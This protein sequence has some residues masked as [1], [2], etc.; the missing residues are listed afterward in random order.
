MNPPTSHASFTLGLGDDVVP[1]PRSSHSAFLVS[2]MTSLA[3]DFGQSSMKTPRRR[4]S[5]SSVDSNTSGTNMD[6][7]FG[8]RRMSSSSLDRGYHTLSSA[9]PTPDFAPALDWYASPALAGVSPSN[10]QLGVGFLPNEID[11]PRRRDIKRS[12]S[13]TKE[14]EPS[15]LF[16]V[17]EKKSGGK[18]VGKP[19]ARPALKRKPFSPIHFGSE[20]EKLQSPTPV[21]P[22]E[23]IY[24]GSRKEDGFDDAFM[25][26]DYDDGSQTLSSSLPVSIA[27]LM[28]GQIT[29]ISCSTATQGLS[30][31]I[32]RDSPRLSVVGSKRLNSP[33][34]SSLK[35]CKKMRAHSISE[36]SPSRPSVND[37]EMQ[38]S[39]PIKRSKSIAGIPSPFIDRAYGIGCSGPD[40]I[41]DFSKPFALPV[42]KTSKGLKAI[43]SETLSHL[44]HGKFDS[45]IGSYFVID[46]RF[47]FEFSGGH[48]KGA[49]NLFTKDQIDAFFLQTPLARNK[50][51]DKRLILIFHC[52]FSS[53]RGPNLCSFLRAQ[54]RSIHSDLDKYPGLYYPELYLL[55][56]GYKAFYQ[57]YKD[58]C[59]PKAYVPMIDDRHSKDLT[60]FLKKAKSWSGGEQPGR[61]TGLARKQLL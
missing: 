56:G 11:S 33:D 52:E 3:I 43:S 40:L 35:A 10:N 55:D 18:L 32:S 50:D 44:L 26:T 41:G 21:S 37:L 58:L 30:S 53:Q 34:V 14:N 29:S 60:L 31:V 46:C 6:V 59:E 9:S 54:D 17:P 51:D 19:L 42:L 12:L 1:S 47:P 4:L 20:E 7:S 48:I 24:E 15:P 25:G 8:D 2:P 45:K 57:D 36:G 49:R 22:M 5:M 23:P 27:G 38:T 28:Q 13:S 39:S 16:A 61:R